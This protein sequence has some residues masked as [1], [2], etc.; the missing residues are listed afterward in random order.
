MYRQTSAEEEKRLLLWDRKITI[1]LKIEGGNLGVFYEE[2]SLSEADLRQFRIAKE[3]MLEYHVAFG[4]RKQLPK[5]FS[6]SLAVM[7]LRFLE[8]GEMVAIHIACWDVVAC[9]TLLSRKNGAQRFILP[10]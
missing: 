10:G 3:S 4:V 2:E 7:T 8:V 5:I 1:P 6:E 9:L